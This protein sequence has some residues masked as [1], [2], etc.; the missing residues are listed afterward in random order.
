MVLAETRR[1]H[2]CVWTVVRFVRKDVVFGGFSVPADSVVMASAQAMHYDPRF[3]PDPER[4]NPA[5]WTPEAQ[6]ALPEYAYFPFSEG[7]RECAGG[8]FAK[9]QDALI[10]ATLAQRWRACALPNQRIEPAPQKSNTPRFGI[11]M[12]LEPR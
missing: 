3:F 7:I 1:R 11:Q 4:F 12:T 10:L 6:A 9:T 2:P 8:E 5:R